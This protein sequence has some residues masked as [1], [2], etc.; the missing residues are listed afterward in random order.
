MSLYALA[1]H[2]QP[3]NRNVTTDGSL[4]RWTER[5]GG[6][7]RSLELLIPLPVTCS[8]ILCIQCLRAMQWTRAIASITTSPHFWHAGTIFCC[9]LAS[10][11]EKQNSRRNTEHHYVTGSTKWSIYTEFIIM[12]SEHLLY[13]KRENNLNAVFT[14]KILHE[15]RNDDRLI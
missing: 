4:A 7:W 11:L 6:F 14:Q 15:S 2:A 12:V 10:L 8:G 3:L 13:L 1:H 9:F 5:S